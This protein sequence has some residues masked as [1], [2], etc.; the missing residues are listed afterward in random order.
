MNYYHVAVRLKDKSSYQI[1]FSDLSEQDLRKKFVRPY[2]KGG[3]F[4]VGHEFMAATSL[5]AVVI[6]QT[7]CEEAAIRAEANRQGRELI[8]EINHDRHGAL[9]IAEAPLYGALDLIESGQDVSS[10]YI[11][12]PPGVTFR[13]HVP[14]SALK[15]LAGLLTTVIGGGVLK[16]LG[17]V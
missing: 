15:W 4:I 7:D 13:W 12:G 17:W 9:F 14:P 11:K 16:W 3:T 8:D 2:E 5:R 10:R 1:L 6:V